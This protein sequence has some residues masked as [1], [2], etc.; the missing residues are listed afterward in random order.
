M[1]VCVALVGACCVQYKLRHCNVDQ[2]TG[3][4]LEGSLSGVSARTS[5]NSQVTLFSYDHSQS[6][7]RVCMVSSHVFPP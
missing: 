4:Y 5:A 1:H 3:G 6:T 7:T 2:A